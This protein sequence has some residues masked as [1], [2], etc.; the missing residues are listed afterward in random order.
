LHF[1][2][3]VFSKNLQWRNDIF[4]YTQII[5]LKKFKPW[6]LFFYKYFKPWII[7]Q[8]GSLLIGTCQWLI[9]GL[10]QIPIWTATFILRKEEKKSQ[11][12]IGYLF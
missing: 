8:F 11:H 4:I 10:V 2:H 7:E 1:N 3:W 9:R 12:F 6:K 5:F